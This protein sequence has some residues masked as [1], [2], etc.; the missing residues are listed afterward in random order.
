MRIVATGMLV[1]MAA[2]FFVARALEQHNPAWG[3][4]RAFAE[5]A[6]VGGLADWFAVT[7]LFRHPLGLPIPHTAIIPRNK[8]RIGDTL[9]AFLKDNFLI[10]GVVARRMRRVD[11]AGTAGRFLA[12]PTEA[13]GRTRE[14]AARIVADVMEALDQERLGGMV[15]GLI[16]GRLRALD[17]APMLGQALQAAIAKDRHIPLLEG[18][19]RWAARTLEGNEHLI[20][21]MVHDRAGSILRWTGLDETLADKIMDGLLRLLDDLSVDPGH[22]VRLKAEDALARLA[23]DLQ[24]DPVMQA[25]VADWRDELLDND[26]MRRWLD[27]L[28]EQGRAALLRAARNPRGALGGKFGETLRQLGETLQNDERLRVTINRFARRSAVGFS[29]RYGESIVKLVS[30]TVRSWDTRTITRRL[31]DAVGRDLQYIRVNGTIVGGLVGL[32]IHAVEV[33]L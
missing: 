16:D 30:E 10:P 33:W 25:R 8:D 7:A 29:A 6:M 2:L 18:M 24:F 11:L 4:V 27:G 15:K 12:N 9:A 23:E 19:I 17:A 13:E 31:E 26:A 22:P 5:A 21:Q 3:F 14:A 32:L 20:R 1:A 28:W